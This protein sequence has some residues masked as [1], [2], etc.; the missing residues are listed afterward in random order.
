MIAL[1]WRS[2]AL[3][4]VFQSQ[5]LPSY[6]PRPLRCFCYVNEKSGLRTFDL[7][8]TYDLI[9]RPVNDLAAHQQHR[10]SVTRCSVLGAQ[11]PFQYPACVELANYY[12]CF[13]ESHLV[14][15]Q[16][17]QHVLPV[18]ALNPEGRLVGCFVTAI[19]LYTMG[20]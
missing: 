16:E 19:T 5:E 13:H 1:K 8:I 4:H 20:T 18:Y 3:I 10:L 6:L 12:S 14:S 9:E 7:G 2:G 15:R 11:L 17:Q